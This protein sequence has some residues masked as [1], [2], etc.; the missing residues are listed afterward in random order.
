MINEIPAL[1]SFVL[2]KLRASIEQDGVR[3]PIVEDE[4]GK[5]IDGHH[6][7]QI[8][9]ELGIECPSRTVTGLTEPEKYQLAWTLNLS[10][11]HLS[12][13][14]KRAAWR[15]HRGEVKHLLQEDPTRSDRS[16]GEQLGVHHSTVAADRQELESSGELA[17]TEYQP[18]YGGGKREER[19]P[20]AEN[21]ADHKNETW[22]SVVIGYACPSDEIRMR[23]EDPYPKESERLEWKSGRLPLTPNAPSNQAEFAVLLAE[24]FKRC[25]REVAERPMKTMTRR[26]SIYA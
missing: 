16:I 12:L 23:G 19:E 21:F 18:S 26:E 5:I 11:R 25:Q 17:T 15:E 10:R 9:D 20:Q 3:E 24:G 14:Q 4:F 2:A 22:I 6:R 8:A 13:E 1:D 7:K